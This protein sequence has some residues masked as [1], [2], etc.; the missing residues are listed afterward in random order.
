MADEWAWPMMI[1]KGRCWSKIT[2]AHQIR[3]KITANFDNKVNPPPSPGRHYP[4]QPI[5]KIL[6]DLDRSSWKVFHAQDNSFPSST[7]YSVD[8]HLI[9]IAFYTALYSQDSGDDWFVRVSHSILGIDACLHCMWHSIPWPG[10][11]ICICFLTF[12]HRVLHHTPWIDAWFALYSTV[13]YD[14]DSLF[15]RNLW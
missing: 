10:Q 12:L 4:I 15:W 9:S 1:E 14:Q 5:T 2:N 11:S 13:F 8:E 3:Q 6:R 7:Q